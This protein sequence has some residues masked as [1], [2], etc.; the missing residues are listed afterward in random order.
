MANRKR[1]SGSKK[2]LLQFA[3]ATAILTLLD[4]LITLI[5]KLI[6]LFNK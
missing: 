1:K 2:Q 3:F 6:E 5:T 4:N